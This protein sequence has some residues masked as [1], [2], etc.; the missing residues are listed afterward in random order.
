MRRFGS[1]MSRVVGSGLALAGFMFSSFAVADGADIGGGAPTQHVALGQDGNGKPMIA[2]TGA[3]GGL[4][5]AGGEGGS[6]T[7]TGGGTSLT[8]SSRIA[9]VR[10]IAGND[11]GGGFD[12]DA[13]GAGNGFRA[14]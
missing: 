4:H 9:H 8:Y 12:A 13:S 2:G 10:G 11:G 5:F 3:G 1:L 14:A 7:E 6:G